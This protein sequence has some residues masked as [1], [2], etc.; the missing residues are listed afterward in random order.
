MTLLTTAMKRMGMMTTRSSQTTK[1][2][3]KRTESSTHVVFC[4]RCAKMMMMMRKRKTRIKK[5]KRKDEKRKTLRR[6]K[7]LKLKMMMKMRRKMEMKMAMKMKRKVSGHSSECGVVLLQYRIS[8][9]QCPAREQS[10]SSYTSISDTWPRI[11]DRL[12]R[13]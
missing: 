5:T 7:T 11:G 9:A 6:K 13:S 10:C 3:T 12:S 8:L 1:T 2:M 4:K